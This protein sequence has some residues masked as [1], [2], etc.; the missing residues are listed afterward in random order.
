MAHILIVDD[1]QAICAS[2]RLLLKQAGFSSSQAYNPEEALSVLRKLSPDLVIMDM[3]FSR[4]TTGSEGLSL[5]SDIRQLGE[6]IPVILITAWGSIDLAVQ[7][8]RLGAFDFIN[9]PWDNQVLLRSIETALRLRLDS[10]RDS[11]SKNRQ[12]LDE[13]YDFGN[14]IGEDPQ[15]LQVLETVGRVSATDASILILGDSGT[16]KEL[17]AEAIH[18]NSDR[19][20][21]PFIKVNLGGISSSL[22]DSEMFGHKRGAFTDA[23]QDR[24]GRFEK[25]HQGTIFLD[26]IG[27]LDLNSQVKL[28]RVLQDRCFEVLGSSKTIKVDFRVIAATNRDL[29]AMVQ[30]G[31]FRED[32]LYRINL[33]TVR[34]PALKDRPSDIP[35]LTQHYLRNLQDLYARPNLNFELS[36]LSWLQHQ[37]WSGNIR[38]LKNLI[39]RTVLVSSHDRI[40]ARDI[41]AQS[42]SGVAEVQPPQPGTLE[43]MEISM[44][45]KALDEHDNNISK[46]AQALG[47]SRAALYRRLEK[48]G[49][50]G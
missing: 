39:E 27:D 14:I 44:I 22:F 23:K 24:I 49:L 28:M 43:D 20:A 29:D 6:D 35:K 8:M 25:A 45:R 26:E 31:D 10:T 47:L 33:I 32:L 38:E 7:G 9:K 12:Q 13:Q 40:S 1:D 15:M 5:L 21:G 37:D 50:E 11:V 46:V 2:L 41:S 17:I 3:N 4:E 42:Q 30:A 48:Y 34:L 18:A 19:H 36:A 16:G